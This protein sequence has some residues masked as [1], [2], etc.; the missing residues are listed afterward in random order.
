MEAL[1]AAQLIDNPLLQASVLET[2]VLLA[3]RAG[4]S[5]EAASAVENAYRLATQAGAGARCTL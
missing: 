5:W 3:V 2:L 1:A 4:R